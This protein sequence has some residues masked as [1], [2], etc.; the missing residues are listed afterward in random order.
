MQP[1]HS[2]VGAQRVDVAPLLP[3][4]LRRAVAVDVRHAQRTV[5]VVARVGGQRQ[6]AQQRAVVAVDGDAAL[7]LGLK[8]VDLAPPL[9][10][11]GDAVAVEVGHGHRLGLGDAL[12]RQRPGPIE[13]P[14][15]VASGDDLDLAVAVEIGHDGR[16][17]APGPPAG[18]VLAVDVRRAQHLVDVAGRRVDD[19]G[20]AARLVL[21]GGVAGERAAA[22]VSCAHDVVRVAG[23]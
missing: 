14:E 8:G 12:P 3:E 20:E 10:H 19:E 22:G 5:D 7:Q 18:A 2:P 4:E 21:V 16:V 23:P 9:D 13:A 1:Q 17:V 6:L 11:L 15:D